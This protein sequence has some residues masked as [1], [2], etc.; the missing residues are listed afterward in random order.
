ME[1]RNFESHD[2]KD[3]STF[4]FIYIFGVVI[5]IL[6]YYKCRGNLVGRQ[7]QLLVVD[8][9]YN[10]CLSPFSSLSPM[11]QT[12]NFIF[13]IF[14][15]F[16]LF[17]L[18]H[19]SF[20]RRSKHFILLSPLVFLSKFFLCSSYLTEIFWTCWWRRKRKESHNWEYWV[21]CFALRYLWCSLSRPSHAKMTYRKEAE[22]LMI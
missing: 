20:L 3:V 12:T 14:I 17:V 21:A 8:W 16:S 22:N 9:L 10:S 11:I 7:A 13:I 4:F 19:L 1:G 5:A 18:G 6:N 2:K 15:S